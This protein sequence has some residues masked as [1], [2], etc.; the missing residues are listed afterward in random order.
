MFSVIANPEMIAMLY[1]LYVVAFPETLFAG[2]EEPT[3]EELIEWG[4]AEGLVNA[5]DDPLYTVLQ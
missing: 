5:H 1:D 2:E 3:S 4:L